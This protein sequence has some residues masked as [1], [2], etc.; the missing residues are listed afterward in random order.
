MFRDVG[1]PNLLGSVRPR[2]AAST[3]KDHPMK[4]TGSCH[5]GAIA[6]EADIDPERVTICHCTDC[7]KLTGSAYR[8]SVGAPAAAFRLLAGSPTIYVKRADS[9]AGR[10][11]GLCATCGSPLYTYDADQPQR[12]GIRWGS[13]D[14]RN[15]LRPARQI[16]CRSALPW[17][18]NIEGLPGKERE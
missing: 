2:G 4:I 18:M 7:Q 13:V 14:Q 1:G 6:Y 12:L 15:D 3:A 9:G 5:C 17:A 16:W 11:E 10:A 8:V